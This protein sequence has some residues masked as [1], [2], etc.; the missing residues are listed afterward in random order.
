MAS[1]R[2]VGIYGLC[3]VGIYGIAVE[4]SFCVEK[5]CGN[6]FSKY[7]TR[8]H[9]R[10]FVRKFLISGKCLKSMASFFCG[11]CILFEFIE[12]IPISK[13]RHCYFVYAAG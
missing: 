9:G 3:G 4:I 1:A 12:S 13:S 7:K 10:S 8:K 2:C 11:N 6:P 5:N